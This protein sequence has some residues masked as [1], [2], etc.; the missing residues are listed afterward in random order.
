MKPGIKT[1]NAKRKEPRIE[2]PKEEKVITQS[3]EPQKKKGCGCNKNK[4]KLR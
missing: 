3:E 4:A 1:D 2:V